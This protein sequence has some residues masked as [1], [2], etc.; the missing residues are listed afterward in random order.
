M[1]TLIGANQNCIPRNEY[2]FEDLQNP[3]HLPSEVL[4]LNIKSKQEQKENGK[5]E[6]KK[7][8]FEILE[9][10]KNKSKKAT[11]YQREKIPSY[12]YFI[13]L[14]FAIFLIYFHL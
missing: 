5:E 2:R 9:V 13:H 7:N 3:Q 12:Y 11:N 6:E 4:N 14:I 8:L 10:R 1:Q